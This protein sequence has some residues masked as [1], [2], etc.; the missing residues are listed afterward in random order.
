MPAHRARPTPAV[1][2]RLWRA[3]ALPILIALLATGCGGKD[4]PKAKEKG[5][6]SAVAAEPRESKSAEEEEIA[7]DPGYGAPLQGRCYRISASRSLA[8][9][10]R[11]SR[12]KCSSKHTTVVARVAYTPK[13][14][15][16][17]TPLPKRRALGKRLCEPAYRRLAGGTVADRAT[18]LLTWTLFTPSRDQLERGARWVRCD[19]LARSGDQL[20]PLPDAKPLLR[21]GV[22]ES[23]RVCQTASGA[24]VSCSQTHAF[25]VEAVFAAPPRVYPDPVRYT[26]AARSRCKQLTGSDGGYWQPP[27]KPGWRSGDRF[28]RCLSKAA[29]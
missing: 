9:V 5:K 1:R 27:S 23:L 18:S 20:V 6:D 25:R 28:V 14:V 16:S 29:S 22:P 12:V 4:E 2:Q 11:G 7:P 26:A 13:A 10:T 19:V 21:Q 15:T 3:L 17:K 8:P 24:D